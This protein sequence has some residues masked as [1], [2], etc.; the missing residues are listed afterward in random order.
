MDDFCPKADVWFSYKISQS[1]KNGTVTPAE[2][3][4]IQNGGI[5][6]I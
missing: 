5:S 6:Y 3:L 1:G 2:L 4:N